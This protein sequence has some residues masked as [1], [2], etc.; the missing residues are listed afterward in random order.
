MR[1]FSKVGFLLVP[2]L[3]SLLSGC[4]NRAPY[5]Y[6]ALQAS[7]PCSIVVIPPNNNTV[8]VNAQYVFL[9][10][11]SKPLAEKGYYVFP[12]SVIDHFL[13][14]NGLPTPAEM[15]AVPLDKIGENIG[16]DAVLYVS[17]ENWGQKFELLSSR[18][19]VH[20]KLRLVDVKTG[21]QLWDAVAYAE[22]KSGDG[23]GGLMGALV[24]AI[25]EQIAGSIVD[26]TPQLSR[27]A[28]RVAIFN[29]SRGL[30]NGPYRPEPEVK[31]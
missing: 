28:N 15:N 9:S 31:K 26:R 14:E 30:L 6:T 8:E 21:E 5:D 3:V 18:A 11:I 4:V 29:Q 27:Q 25:A 24:G 1:L 19:V 17:I 23:G 13:K 22:Y 16:A 20:A 7:K 12:V 10:T 2:V